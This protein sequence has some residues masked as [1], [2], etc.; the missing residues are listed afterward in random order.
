MEHIKDCNC[1]FALLSE[2][3][4]TTIKNDVTAKVRTHGYLV[5]HNI[6]DITNGKQRGGGV[7]ILYLANYNLKKLIMPKYSSFEHVA[8]NLVLPSM[9]KI[10]IV[11]LYRLQH[12]PINHFFE[13]FTELLEALITMNSTL[14]IGG[15]VNIHLDI[16]SNLNTKEFTTLLETF[17]LHQLVSASTHN[18]GHQLEVMITNEPIKFSG[19]SVDD[20]C[21]SD[22]YR[23][24]SMLNQTERIPNK[25]RTIHYRDIKSMD[26]GGFINMVTSEL[27][28]KN[29]YNNTSFSDCIS[30][31]N[32]TLKSSLDVFA[33]LK[34]KVVKDVPRA[35]WFDEEYRNLRKKRRNAEKLWRKTKLEVH[36]SIFIN[37]RNET[38]SLAYNKKRINARTKINN[39]ENSQKTLYATLNELTG[40]NEPP[41]YPDSSDIRNANDF[42]NFFVNKVH[43]IRENLRDVKITDLFPTGSSSYASNTPYLNSFELCTMSEISAIIKEHGLKCSFVDPTPASVLNTN[44]D[45]FLPLWSHLVN[46]SLSSGSIDGLLKQADIIPLLKESGLDHLIHGNFR[47]VS[48]LQFVS[49]L[50]ERVVA[51]RLKCHMQLN[52]LETDNQYGY[53]KG[54]STETILVKITNDI[55]IASDKKSATVLL[56]LDLSAAFDT[57]NVDRLLDILSSEIGI[58][59]TALKWFHSFLKNRTMRV[60][61][62]NAF[63][64]VF[65]LEFRVPQGSVLGPILFN[66]YIRSIYKHIELTGFSIK[67]FAD[68]HQVY[69]SFSPEFQ[70]HFLCQQIKLVMDLIEKLMNCYFLKLNPK[71]TQIIVFGPESVRKKIIINGVFIENDK[72]CV[73]FRSVVQNLGVFLDAGMSYDKQ[74]KKVVSSS[75]LSI[76]NISRIKGFLTIKEKCTLLTSLVLSKIDYCNSLY[77]GMNCSLLKK[78]QVVQNSAVRLVFNKQKYD[79]SSALLFKLHWLPVKDRITYKIS[80]LVHKAL[81]HP[82]PTDIQHLV[83]IHSARTFNLTSYYRSNS[84]YGDRSFTVFAP[85]IWNTLPM[86]LKTESSLDKFKSNLKT[87]LFR[88]AFL[89]E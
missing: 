8:C 38:T 53:K 42:A 31:Y 82:V 37:L 57:V 47:P 12:V 33:P 40:Q 16:P 80:L 23:I 55:L 6:R 89:S 77:Y 20:V 34:E 11:S 58:G 7:A 1:D 28:S 74:V 67:G 69:I 75:F 19:T 44:I 71:K 2:T 39:S 5:H 24:S 84:T 70:L 64:E 45:I 41:K 21:L 88:N 61:V 36:K 68:D 86:Y 60:K 87:F 79:H 48:H 78:L 14:V 18:Q 81:Y 66:I 26:N 62:N 32:N 29:I 52:N 35:T 65:E 30:T 9:R 17:G 27:E 49:K 83:V 85:K 13:E 73:R 22:H 51:K 76:K 46:L 54:H 15:D 59:G 50:I 4:L 72:T 25:L 56:L 3:W 63:S 43:R 10:V